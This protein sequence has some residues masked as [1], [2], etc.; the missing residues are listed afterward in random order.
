MLQLRPA[1]AADY[2]YARQLRH[3][4]Y[5]DMAVRHFGPWDDAVQDRFFDK[6]WNDAPYSVILF[7]GQPCGVCR[8][9]E[10]PHCIQLVEFAIDVAQQ[11]R[12]IGAVFLERFKEMGKEKSR[13]AQLNVLKTNTRAKALYERC[14]FRVYGEN[15]NQFLMRA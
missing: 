1:T 8:I 5:R 6:S 10:H 3:A 2:E 15:Q 12:G 4:A 9:D 14:G 11:G 13:A 7:D